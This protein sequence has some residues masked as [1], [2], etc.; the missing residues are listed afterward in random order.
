MSRILSTLAAVA[1]ALGQS[2]C[3][4]VPRSPPRRPASF[5]RDIAIGDL[6][7]K[8]PAEVRERLWVRET[9]HDYLQEARLGPD[10]ETKVRA[11]LDL[12]RDGGSCVAGAR[13]QFRLQGDRGLTSFPRFVFR[14]GR[15]DEMLPLDGDT[16]FAAD[17]R[18]TVTCAEGYGANPVEEVL[19]LAF[20]GPWAAMVAAG[21]LPETVARASVR[22]ELAKLRLGEP[23][24]G[25]LEAY[26]KTPPADVEVKSQ[27]P[28]EAVITLYLGHDRTDRRVSPVRV[29]VADGRVVAIAKEQN[30][31]TPC[32]LDDRAFHCGGTAA[33]L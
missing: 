9:D 32:W 25:G 17:R 6:I 23:P 4:T 16:A 8:S 7:G 26:A 2:A 24:P 15:L 12:L 3:A 11:S 22:A 20:F 5:E 13:L 31:F 19:G 30:D 28:G 29:K 1:V 14:N 27:G 18:I 21:R 10:G 33:P